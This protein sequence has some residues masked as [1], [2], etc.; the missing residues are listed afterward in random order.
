MPKIVW[1][2]LRCSHTRD[3]K[4]TPQ[5]RCLCGWG[6]HRIRN[7]LDAIADANRNLKSWN[8]QWSCYHGGLDT[9]ILSNYVKGTDRYCIYQNPTHRHPYREIGVT[10]VH[11]NFTHQ[12]KSHFLLS[13]HINTWNKQV[14]II[15]REHTTIKRLKKMIKVHTHIKLPKCSTPKFPSKLELST[16][17]NIHHI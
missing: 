7:I 1:S 16:D 11:N 12:L 5:L 8:N 6:G 3:T 2:R 4:F 17:N 15:Q 13:F 9:N 10:R 14:Q